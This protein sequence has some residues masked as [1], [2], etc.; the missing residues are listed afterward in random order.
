VGAGDAFAAGVLLGLH[1]GESVQTALR[2]GVATA[3]ACL[4]TA[5]TSDGIKPL[6]E[7]LELTRTLRFRNLE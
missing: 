6:E 5:G 7:C 4:Q 1:E 3:T 2:Y